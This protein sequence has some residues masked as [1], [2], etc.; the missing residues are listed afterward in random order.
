MAQAILRPSVL[1][2]I[3]IATAG[4][5]FELQI[6]ESRVASDSSLVDKTLI[7][8]GIRKDFGVIIVG[9][10]KG[11]G[12]MHFN[13]EP[14]TIIEAGDTLITLG[15]PASIARL[16]KLASSRGPNV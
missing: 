14:S 1:D 7:N 2:F 12:A 6:E 11:D 10:K 9:I 15:E 13:P 8:S 4:K 3:E 5:N 16:E